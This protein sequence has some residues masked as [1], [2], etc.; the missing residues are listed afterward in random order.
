MKDA[1]WG[2]FFHVAS[3]AKEHWHDHCEPGP[4][5]WYKYQQDIAN[6]TNT[7]KPGPGLPKDVIKHVKSILVD[8]TNDDLLGKCLHGTAQNQNESFNNIIWL[9]A[10]KGTYVGLKALEISVYDAVSNFNVGKKQPY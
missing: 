8:L 10:P 7:Y 5:S 9:R 4:G 1:I 3:S 2:G 6:K